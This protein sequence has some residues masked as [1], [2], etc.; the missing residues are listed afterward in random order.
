MLGLVD[1]GFKG[2]HRLGVAVVLGHAEC[3]SAKELVDGLLVL[4]RLSPGRPVLALEEQLEDLIV[5]PG[6]VALRR[7]PPLEEEPPSG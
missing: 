1:S 7:Q 3:H 6:P 4:E 2:G 5:E